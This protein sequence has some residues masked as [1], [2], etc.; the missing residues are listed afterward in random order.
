MRIYMA[1][2]LFTTAEQDFNRALATA[3]RDL[4]HEVFL[5]QES[6]QDVS[7]LNKIFR[8]DVAG[9]D[10]AQLVLGNLDGADSDSGT[11]W[12][13]GY[14]YAKGKYVVVYRTDF[15]VGK[16]DIVNLMM[17]ESAN[18]VLLEPLGAIGVLAERIHK[19]IVSRFT[20]QKTAWDTFADGVKAEAAKQTAMWP[21]VLVGDGP[22]GA[23]S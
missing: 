5:P 22:G 12:E 10:W 11:C 19:E 3:L 23:R 21:N 7:D 20:G 14:G 1:G 18:V 17:T 6:E 4:G 13:L 8:S 15:R 2:G 16:H 9:I